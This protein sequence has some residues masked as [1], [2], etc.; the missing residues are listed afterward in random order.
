[1]KDKYIKIIEKFDKDSLAI[2]F[3]KDHDVY[4]KGGVDTK[5]YY[6]KGWASA[7]TFINENLTRLDSLYEGGSTDKELIEEKWFDLI[8]YVRLSY[9]ML[10]EDKI[11]FSMMDREHK[12]D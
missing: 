4:N 8:N 12:H 3:D 5:D 11:P 1:M 9:A 10:K 7:H 2:I 6:P